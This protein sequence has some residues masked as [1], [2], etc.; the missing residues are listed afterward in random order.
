MLLLVAYNQF[1][2][3]FSIS[4]WAKT[5]GAAYINKQG[6]RTVSIVR[7]G[8]FQIEEMTMP[9]IF[10]DLT[11]GHLSADYHPA[12]KGSQGDDIPY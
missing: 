8:V 5:G 2:L 4:I 6:N 12:L 3:K 7:F 9:A 1:S 10:E 11:T